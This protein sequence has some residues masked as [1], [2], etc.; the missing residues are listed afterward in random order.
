MRKLCVV[1]PSLFLI[2]ILALAACSPAEGEPTA[3]LIIPT[4]IVA[5]QEDVQQEQP[6]ATPTADLPAPPTLLPT[7]VPSAEPAAQETATAVPTPTPHYRVAFVASDD[8]LNVRSGPGINNGVVGELAPNADGVQIT[9]E[10]EIVAGSTWTPIT[11]GSLSGWVN[12]RF[13]TGSLESETFCQDEAVLDLLVDLETAVTNQDSSL[14]AQLIHPERGLR[15]HHAWWN[16][17][18]RLTYDEVSEIFTSTAVYDWGIED[19][20][21]SPIVGP[22]SQEILPLLQEDLLLADDTACDEILHGGTAGIVRLPDG[23][24]AVHYYAF[25]RPGTDEFAGMNWGSWVVGI[26]QWQGTYYVSYL[27]HYQWEI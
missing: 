9:G 27:V 1:R 14:L 25:F 12:G 24:D 5:V 23:Y 8:T 18:V 11:A 22:F 7:P 21:G 4:A 15:I 13:L 26:E 10:G 16:P 20:S 6:P 17:E 3:E 2:L 19:G